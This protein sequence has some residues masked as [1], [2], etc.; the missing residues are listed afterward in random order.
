MRTGT[1]SGLFLQPQ[2]G[3]GKWGELLYWAFLLHWVVPSS[4]TCLSHPK[5]KQQGSMLFSTALGLPNHCKKT[6]LWMLWEALNWLSTA[7]NA[8][9]ALEH[10]MHDALS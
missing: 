2:P 7:P 9:S 1:G 5:S 4:S 3:H 8:S 6:T 10:A